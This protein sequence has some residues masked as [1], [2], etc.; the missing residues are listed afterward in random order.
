V[1]EHLGYPPFERLLAE[2]DEAHRTIADLRGAEEGLLLLV[3]QHLDGR[4]ADGIP[5]PNTS[6]RPGTPEGS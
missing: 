2:V 5:P 4:L 6:S 1:P 3:A